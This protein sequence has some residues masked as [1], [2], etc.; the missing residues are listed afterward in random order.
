MDEQ[1]K[2]IGKGERLQRLKKSFEIDPDKLTLEIHYGGTLMQVVV[3][4]GE[5]EG[6][7]EGQDGNGTKN[8]EVNMQ[9]ERG[10]AGNA[11]ANEEGDEEDGGKWFQIGRKWV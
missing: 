8:G 10:G 7:N 4:K 3:R 1:M 2:T 6:Q 11:R 9:E 5:Y